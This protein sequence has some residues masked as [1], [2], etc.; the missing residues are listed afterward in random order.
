MLTLLLSLHAL[1]GPTPVAPRAPLHYKIVAKTTSEI[2]L[3]AM[4]QPSTSIVMTV[5]G[6]VSVSMTDTV[7]GKL[8]DIVVDSS[9]FDAGQF[10]AAMPAT[11]TASSQG[12]LFHVY[13]VNGKP[14]APITSKSV[15]VQA[16]QLVPGIEIL[17]AGMR[18]S[19]MAESW[20]DTTK[21]DT[22]MAEGGAASTRITTW[23][24]K[25]GTG[26]RIEIDGTWTGTT[27]A[28]VGGGQMEMQ[29]TGTTHLTSMP[30]ALTETGTSSG[31]GQASMN[32]GGSAI[33]MKVTTEVT[34][35]ATP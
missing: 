25:A 35:S 5:S 18:P 34:T 29:I 32:I 11:M 19:R 12:T 6:F 31:S 4:G 24:A 33:P 2:D 17:L 1:A 22:T 23:T 27:T 20:V 3:S 16:A 15:S 7:G 14:S 21:S 28:S 13:L 26:G 8:A 10:T 30:G 9:A